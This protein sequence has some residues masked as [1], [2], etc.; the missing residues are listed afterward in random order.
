MTADVQIG[1]LSD[2]IPASEIAL[3]LSGGSEIT[4]FVNGAGEIE[5]LVRE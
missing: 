1:K 2:W 5:C 4:F 3:F